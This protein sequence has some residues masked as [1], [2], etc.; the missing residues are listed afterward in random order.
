VRYQD[1]AHTF[2]VQNP[3][4]WHRS[5]GSLTPDLVDPHEILA[6][7]T[8]DLRPG[9]PNCAHLPVQALTDLAP[10]D[11]LIWVAERERGDVSSYPARPVAFGPTSGTDT[12]ESPDCLD[13]RSGSST[14]GSSSRT[15]AAASPPWSRWART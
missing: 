14:A 7:G 9:G 3:Q 1:P 12:D 6:L 4:D 10:G 2:S 11:S 8:F 15:R 13:G 5:E